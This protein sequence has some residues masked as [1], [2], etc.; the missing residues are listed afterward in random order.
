MEHSE[1][2]ATPSALATLDEMSIRRALSEFATGVTVVTTSGPGGPYGFACQSFSSLSLNPPLVLFTVMKSSRT[3]PHIEAS[4]TF[5]VN[6]LT[7]EQK[8]VSAAFG[9]RG[10]EKFSHGHWEASPLGN[11]VLGGCAIWIDCT[12]DAVYDGG[13]H[14]IVVGAIKDI[15]HRQD[16]CPLVYHRGSYAK[17]TASGVDAPASEPWRQRPSV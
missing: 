14:H 8:S 6:V 1:A 7:E 5:T 3:W 17:L 11:P 12:V 4:G 15:G 16:S 2:H 13:D 10:E 9:R